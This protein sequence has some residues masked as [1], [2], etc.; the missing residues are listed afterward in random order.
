MD[1]IK[2]L[3]DGLSTAF[4]NTGYNSNLAYRP[5]F[6]S[7]DYKKG[8]KVLA[9]IEQ[10]LQNCDEFCISV[11]F[12][13]QSGIE[14][15]LMTL[16][17]LEK[18]NIPGKILTTD[19]LTFSEPKALKC[20]ASLKNIK[21]KMFRT[22]SEAG[23][24][25][26]K[27]YIFRKKEIYRIIIGSSNLT[28][29]A[30]T[31]NREWNTKIVSAEEGQV[32]QDILREFNE[33]WS[34]K[35]SLDYDDVID[36]YQ[37]E[38]LKNQLIKKQQKQAL[39]DQVIDLDRYT[40][41]PNK[42]QRTFIDNVMKMRQNGVDRALLLSSTGTGKS[43][44]SAFALREM[45]PKKMLFLV[46]RE[47]I[48]KQTIRSYKRVFG[49]TKTYGLLSGTSKDKNI[50]AEY[51]FS[52]I[53][54]MK[55]PEIH[56][57]F[58]K[59]E[60]DIIV[61]DECHHVGSDSYQQT[62]NYFKP[63]FWLGMTATP[64][65]K[66]YDIYEIF[67][68]QIAYEIRLQQA[69]EEDLLCPFHYFGI[70]DLEINGEVF[71]DNAGVRNFSNLVSDARV[72]YVIQKAEYYGYSGNRVKGL[73]FCSRK[74]EAKELSANFNRHGYRT[75]VLTGEDSP[76]RREMVIERLT[77]DDNID[78]QLDYIFT[79]DIFNEGVDI[80]EINQ[81]IMLRPTESP[82]VFIQQLGR[83]LRKYE[84]K[85]Y[86]VILD[87]IGN[88]MNNFMIPIALSGDRTYN[89]DA[90]RKYVI[91]GN[92][93]IPGASTI[94]FDEISKNKI[95]NSIDGF[96]GIKEIIK[97]SYKNLKNRLG[98]IPYLMDFYNEGE[99]DP[100]LILSKYKTYQA[101]LEAMEGKGQ[102]GKLSE[103]EITTLEYLSRNI[104]SG[105]RPHELEILQELISTET[106]SKEDVQKHISKKYDIYVNMES[107]DNAIS[108]LE[109]KFVSKSDELEKYCH[110]DIVQQDVQGRLRRLSSFYE[111]LKHA[112]FSRQ[113]NDILLLGLRRYQ[114][115]YTNKNNYRENF[116]LYEKYSRRDV[117]L[118]LNWGKDYSSTMYGMKRIKDNVCLF[119]TYHKVMSE[120]EQKYVNGKPD[121]ADEFMN[122]QTFLWD[123]QIGKGPDSSY[124]HDV[125]EAKN[126]HLFVKKSDAE[127]DYYYMGMF[128]IVNI[129]KG[130]KKD[131]SG[132]LKDIAKVELRMHDCVREDLLKYL[133]SIDKDGG[134][135]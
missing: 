90:I 35:S 49:N 116:I 101:F 100:L 27:G 68:H 117:C 3:Q 51:L 104:S 94:H 54:M 75:E 80:P 126:K 48:A 124:M 20:L 30:I 77:D 2:E 132:K 31:K 56:T 50:D 114:D 103:S 23:G 108:V 83:G 121:Y 39:Q 122:N 53:Q 127:M 9:S 118:L 29:S 33:L 120:D 67:N 76:E 61:L 91:S 73:I 81:V 133:K 92:N 109:G 41:K 21:L 5:E 84:D 37:S 22:S 14:P 65:T 66:N 32:T 112:E 64:D 111:R 42:M 24:F 15:L 18:K 130:E 129:E 6:I 98:K 19:Y 17:E 128:D 36:D 69:L 134:E 105:K 70:T 40:L 44:A 62:M 82:V 123:S 71:D 93:V 43:L 74:D 97:Q 55:K 89:K 38:Y 47:Q 57:Q 86:V 96:K 135:K 8:K 10:E 45:Q 58:A 11:A 25:H 119:V 107:I 87:F 12:I 13:K 113:L 7:N 46:H 59:D 110:I 26:T 125:K 115:N 79:V 52:T 88:Y 72:E 16:E 60:F 131:N 63:K 34:D 4:I 95:F 1:K 99:V 102:K 28:L 106:V 85:E 78:N